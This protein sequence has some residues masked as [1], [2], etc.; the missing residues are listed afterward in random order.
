MVKPKA[1]IGTKPKARPQ[2]I[3]GLASA[4]ASEVAHKK[5]RVEMREEVKEEQQGEVNVWTF[6]QPPSIRS[7]S[8][9]TSSLRD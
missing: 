3:S 6:L 9:S 5:Q 2:N 1:Q 4:A 7:S 8:R